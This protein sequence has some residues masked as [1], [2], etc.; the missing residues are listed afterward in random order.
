MQVHDAVQHAAAPLLQLYPVADGSQVV[1][2]VSHARRLNPREDALDRSHTS[3]T[4][5]SDSSPTSTTSLLPRPSRGRVPR[6]GL[7]TRLV[8]HVGDWNWIM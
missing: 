1:T 5:A 2:Q 6:E 4:S 3:C 7:G 8:D